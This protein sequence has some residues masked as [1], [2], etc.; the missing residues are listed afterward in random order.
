MTNNLLEKSFTLQLNEIKQLIKEI[1]I[2]PS[3]E[4]AFCQYCFGKNEVKNIFELDSNGP[5]QNKIRYSHELATSG[6]TKGSEGE[7][8]KDDELQDAIIRV[9][10]KEPFPL[11]RQSFVYRPLDVFGIAIAVSKTNIDEKTKK[12]ITEIFTQL[13][14][15]GNNDE[16]SRLFY[17]MSC[18]LLGIDFHFQLSSVLLTK[19]LLLLC[20]LKWALGKKLLKDDEIGNEDLNNQILKCAIHFKY[21]EKD[22]SKLSLL[23][24]SIGNAFKEITYSNILRHGTLTAKNKQA[25]IDSICT[26]FPL[27]AKQIQI[28][29]K[30]VKGNKKNEKGPRHTIS[31][32]DEY[33]VQDAFHAI[34]RLIFDDVRPEEWTPSYA[35]NQAR[36]D[37]LIKNEQVAI[38]TKMT[39]KGLDQ[40]KVVEE[41]LIDKNYYQTHPSVQHLICFVYDPEK[42]LNNPTAI[43]HDLSDDG[44][45]FSMKVIVSP[46]I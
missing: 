16:W 13:I 39:R 45:D 29:R 9:I 7:N 4:G 30:D 44:S 23:Y 3:P 19:D 18:N 22:L 42:R 40:K 24:Y 41:L 37:F 12:R 36:I 28:R 2:W 21:D 31:F 38:E 11:D 8:L 35:G 17:K 27:F 46:K 15:K 33:D 5:I 6:F 25:M 43:E 10:S 26:N 34:L 14:E 20:L 32:N 1:W